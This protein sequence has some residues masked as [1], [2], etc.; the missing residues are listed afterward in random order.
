MMFVPIFGVVS[1]YQE[2]IDYFA[3]VRT[4]GITVKSALDRT[5]PICGAFWSAGDVG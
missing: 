5:A 4:L 3:A 2:I 1:N